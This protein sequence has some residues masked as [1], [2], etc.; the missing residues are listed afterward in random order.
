MHFNSQDEPILQWEPLIVSH[1]FTTLQP[2]VFLCQIFTTWQEKK[3]RYKGVSFGKMGS[4]C[5]IMR[6]KN[7]KS[8]HHIYKIAFDKSPN[9][10]KNFQVFYLP[11]SSSQI[12]LNPLVEDW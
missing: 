5:H 9:Y 6:K 4:I 10:R 12:W 1:Y 11:L 7:L 2:L 8:S 3:G